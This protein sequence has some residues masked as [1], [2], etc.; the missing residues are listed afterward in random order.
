MLTIERRIQAFVK[1][2]SFLSNLN[3]KMAILTIESKTSLLAQICIMDGLL[4]IISEI[5]LDQ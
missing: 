4:S 2:G 3:L 1:L 5:P